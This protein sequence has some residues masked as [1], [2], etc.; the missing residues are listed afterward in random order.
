[1]DDKARYSGEIAL[2]CPHAPQSTITASPGA[3]SDSGVQEHHPAGSVLWIVLIS[4]APDA[5]G[6]RRG[7]VL[8]VS[9]TACR[10]VHIFIRTRGEP[11][12]IV[13]GICYPENL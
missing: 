9:G 3:I 1:M 7:A 13:C 2:G 10:A 6:V 11:E 4:T 12:H 5:G 8:S